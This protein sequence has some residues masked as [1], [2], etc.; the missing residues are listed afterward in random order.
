MYELVISSHSGLYRYRMRDVLLVVGFHNATPM[1]EF[2]YRIDKTVSLMGEKTTEMALRS[3]AER[4]AGDCGFLLVDSS[5]YPD[6]ESLRY[7]FVMEID[8]VPQDLSEEEVCASLERRLAEANPSYGDKV[9]DG[10]IN[11]VKILF[12]QPETY[13]LYKELMLEL[14][15]AIA[16]L[17]PVT[18]IDNETQKNFFFTLVDDFEEVK[19]QCPQ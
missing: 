7:V 12:S 8:R 3:A 16:Q 6:H 19:G 18:V 2:Q 13:L 4:T 15:N 11:P 5:V 17:K 1:V 14:G 10:L 9:R